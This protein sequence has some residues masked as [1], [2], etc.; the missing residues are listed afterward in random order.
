M[1]Q[2]KRLFN[3]F[4]PKQKADY[5]NLRLGRTGYNTY[6]LPKYE[7]YRRLENSVMMPLLKE[8][9]EKLCSGE[10]DD[11]NGDTLDSIIFGAAREAL[12]DLQKQFLDHSELI[13]R[14]GICHQTDF[15][16]IMRIKQERETELK[17]MEE[18]YEIVCSMF[19]K[20]YKG[21]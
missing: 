8:H 13:N 9:L 4:R 1:F 20:F 16:D 3:F 6:Q 18:S 5:S 17:S 10:I 21:V 11:G 12:P 7:T 19:N 15:Q 2:K 14:Q